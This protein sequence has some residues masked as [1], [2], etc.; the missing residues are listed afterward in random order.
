V[1]LIEGISD[2]RTGGDE[3][4]NIEKGVEKGVEEVVEKIMRT[5]SDREVRKATISLPYHGEC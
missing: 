1:E 3:G 5:R 4:V 2:E